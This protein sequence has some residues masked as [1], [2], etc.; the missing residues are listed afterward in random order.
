MMNAGPRVCV[1]CGKDAQDTAMKDG[2]KVLLCNQHL[3]EEYWRLLPLDKS[4]C[5]V[6]HPG[7]PCGVYYHLA[8]P[9]NRCTCRKEKNFI[10]LQKTC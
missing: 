6:E 7:K 5:Q 1:E 10:A 9:L 3:S 4:P 8:L 2:E